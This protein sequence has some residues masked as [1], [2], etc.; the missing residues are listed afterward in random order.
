MSLV[1]VLFTLVRSGAPYALSP[2]ELAA[3][4]MVSTAAVAQRLNRLDTAGL[5]R[6]EPNPGDGRGRIVTLTAEGKAIA[7]RALPSHL[8]AEEAF[9][10]ALDPAQRIQ[11]NGLLDRLLGTTQHRR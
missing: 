11:L 3:S 4:S 5:V 6:R 7:D 2:T 8:A 9:L 10:A 1:N